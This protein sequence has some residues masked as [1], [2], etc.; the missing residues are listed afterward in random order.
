ML[1]ISLREGDYVVIGGTVKVCYDHMN[2]KDGLVL[3]IDA[4]KDVQVLR[5]K[6]YEEELKRMAD[7]GDAKAKE[8]F[9][10]L[11]KETAKRLR[12]YN[13]RR[14]SRNEQDRRI[15]AGEINPYHKT[16]KWN[17]IKESD[18]NVYSD[19]RNVKVKYK[20]SAVVSE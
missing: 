16:P 6:Y 18:L 1:Y 14:E 11:E 13:K 12:K 9:E 10:K 7:A 2:G 8:L 4:P 3:G 5:G 20:K 19:D 17:G 15:A